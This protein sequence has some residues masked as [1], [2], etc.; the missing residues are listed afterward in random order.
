MKIVKTENAPAANGH[1]VQGL[2]KENLLF[3]S[4]QLPIDPHNPGHFHQDVED[5]TKQVLQNILEIVLAAG[6]KKEDLVKV[7]IYVTDMA[8]WSIINTFYADFMGSHKP[9][10]G[11]VHVQS[12]HLGYQIGMDAMAVL[13]M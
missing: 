12:L 4:M 2:Q 9:A 8:L 10:R 1:Y 7:T 5:Q 6:G 13:T 11:V 3:L